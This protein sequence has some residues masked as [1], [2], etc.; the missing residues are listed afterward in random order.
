MTDKV[1]YYDREFSQNQG[2][3]CPRGTFVNPDGVCVDMTRS[4]T[5]L[6]YDSFFHEAPYRQPL[7][8]EANRTPVNMIG[9][10][11]FKNSCSSC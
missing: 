3:S 5:T 11:P 8:D 4:Q 1:A 2:Q 9:I 10:S 6:P 7:V